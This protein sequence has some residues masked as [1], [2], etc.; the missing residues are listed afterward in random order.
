DHQVGHL[1]DAA[2]DALQLVAGSG[3]LEQHEDVHHGMYGRFAL[4]DSD[5]FDEYRIE[6]GRFAQDDRLARLAGYAAER[7]RRRGRTYEDVGIGR[8]ALHAR[9]VAEYGTPAPLRAGVDGEHGQPV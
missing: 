5:R 4:S 3:N 7:T 9:L 8:N 1:H 6:S 2:F